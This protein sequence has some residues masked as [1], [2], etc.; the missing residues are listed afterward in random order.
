MCLRIHS[1]VWILRRG[2][3][4][5]EGCAYG[6]DSGS[7]NPHKKFNFAEDD[8]LGLAKARRR[9]AGGHGDIVGPYWHWGQ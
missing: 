9:Q 1:R 6:E 8:A 3:C 5:N 2:C 7:N 4:R